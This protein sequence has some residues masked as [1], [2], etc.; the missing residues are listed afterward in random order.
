MHLGGR[1]LVRIS[2][3]TS[4]ETALSRSVLSRPIPYTSGYAGIA[5]CSTKESVSL[6]TWSQGRGEQLPDVLSVRGP[7]FERWCLILPAQL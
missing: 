6:N 4:S 1:K 3:L 5:D 2:C 7:H